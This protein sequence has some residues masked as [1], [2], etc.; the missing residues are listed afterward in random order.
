MLILCVVFCTGS[1][2]G[3]RAADTAGAA[4]GA[5]SAFGRSRT[6]VVNRPSGSGGSGGSGSGGGRGGG[7]GGGGGGGASGG[8][9]PHIGPFA[10]MYAG[11]VAASTFFLYVDGIS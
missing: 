9:A 7:R 2:L 11:L 1:K 3:S 10:L 6:P 8:E 5:G 4:P